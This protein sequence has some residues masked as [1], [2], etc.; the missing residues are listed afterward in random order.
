MG[1]QEADRIIASL[2]NPGQGLTDGDSPTQFKSKLDGTIRSL[3]EV[4]ARRIYTTQKGIQPSSIPLGSM[5][6]VIDK[7]GDEI[8]EQVR[9][10]N[11]GADERQI[12]QVV[13][14]QLKR[15]FGI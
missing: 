7:R 5:G 10:S 9:K 14:Q 1:V 15:E 2:P 11:P 13:E 6:S 8:A 3:K 4:E 12:E